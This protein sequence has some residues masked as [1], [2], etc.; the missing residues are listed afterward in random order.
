MMFTLLGVDNSSELIFQLAVFLSILCSYLFPFW[1]FVGLRAQLV[2]Q[3]LP[4]IKVHI[5]L[6]ATL[7]LGIATSVPFA[8]SSTE[9]ELR[10]FLRISV[11]F[12]IFGGGFLYVSFWLVVT[13]QRVFA[14]RSLSALLFCWG[15]VHVA[16][17]L[18]T[19]LNC[20]NAVDWSSLLVD[21]P[22]FI[23]AVF[24]FYRHSELFFIG[25][26]GVSLLN[27]L[28]E[29]TRK[30]TQQATQKIEYLDT[31][32]VLTGAGNREWLIA[33]LNQDL[34]EASDDK[35]VL[36]AMIGLDRFKLVNDNFGIKQG[37]EVLL[38][39]VNRL[40]G[41]VLKP[42]YIARTGGDLFTIVLHDVSSEQQQELAASHMLKLI[43]KPFALKGH[44]VKLTASVGFANFP[45]HG[46]CAES[47]LQKANIAFHL[48]KRQQNAF[49]RYALGMEEESNRM[50]A[51]GKA[52]R[53]AIERDEFVFYFQPQLNI[54]TRCIEGFEALVRW[55]HPEKGILPP[56][57]FLDDIE[58]LQ[59]SK[60]LD[61]FLLNK[62]VITL[63]AWYKR[64]PG[65]NIP[66]AVN[67]SP[68]QFQSLDLVSRIRD[69]LTE[70]EVPGE[71]L[72]LEITENVAMED[73]EKGMDTIR[74]LQEMGVKVSIDDFGTGYSSLAYL[75]K[76]PI[77]KIKID[78]SFISEMQV[79]D[80]DYTIV[81]SMIKLAHGLGKRVLAE[82][83]EINEQLEL[84]GRMGCDSIQ[85][86]FFYK[87]LPEEEALALLVKSM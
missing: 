79:N 28:Q 55:N 59:M 11:R 5:A 15:G 68:M 29:D 34:V 74:L 12:L 77:D 67:L 10:E 45:E 7:L 72:E 26:L 9:Q 2:E 46:D 38:E 84:L 69:L 14:L 50:L 40:E 44:S 58:Q 22:T 17:A 66:V 13:G 63:S 71:I 39:V 1:A 82:G 19:G 3:P 56:G 65:Y 32:D 23:A 24:D 64:F 20:F 61:E 80:S 21:Y 47:V 54:K 18:M 53:A 16:I 35:F 25:L 76:I 70:H 73:I 86:Y 81:H 4:V 6:F 85:G 31:H 49:Q 41:S 75:R 33:K 37:D 51:A 8:F 83:V 62:A 36:V 27:L 87:P 30:T 48:A 60:A 42:T 43:E 52:L 78:R 57:A